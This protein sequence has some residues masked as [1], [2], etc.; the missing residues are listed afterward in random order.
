V[1]E[2]Q[3]TV[4]LRSSRDGGGSPSGGTSVCSEGQR[5]QQAFADER[6]R[7]RRCRRRRVPGRLDATRLAAY[8]CGSEEPGGRGSKG[9][10][11]SCETL[12]FSGGK[13]CYL[14]GR[15]PIL[16]HQWRGATP[17]ASWRSV[18]LALALALPN[19]SASGQQDV[20]SRAT[21]RSFRV[22][23]AG[24]SYSVSGICS[25][26]YPSFE[27]PR[28]RYRASS[29]VALDLKGAV[30]WGGYRSRPNALAALSYRDVVSVFAYYERYRDGGCG[31]P[32]ENQMFI[33]LKVG[34][35]PGIVTAL[36]GGTVG[37]VVIWLVTR[38]VEN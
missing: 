34:S 8:E 16:A 12:R 10:G 28:L 6:G 1:P 31:R 4:Q 37:A 18:V 24:Y 30:L 3:D 27:V 25:D 20:R 9:Q 7:I 2:H 29:N 11:T 35:R 38:G 14:T 26:H 19:D 17:G 23:E 32:I 36:V 5:L 33:G 22:T 21:A 13:G 15:G